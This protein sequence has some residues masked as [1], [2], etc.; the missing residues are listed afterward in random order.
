MTYSAGGLHG[1][2]FN[3]P[4]RALRGVRWDGS[5]QDWK[6]APGHYGA[7]H[8]SRRQMTDAGWLPG[9]EW[10]VPDGLASGVYA[11]K[12]ERAG[13]EDHVVFFVRPR[14]GGRKQKVAFL[15]ST[16]TYLAYANDQFS[17]YAALIEKRDFGAADAYLHDHPEVGLS[18]YDRHADGS[19]IA[20][21]F[22]SAAPVSI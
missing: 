16:A 7:V 17:M 22:V 9:I 4:T 6:R 14:P 2:F 3:T 5:E 11:M 18:L 10:N 19:G 13:D 12:L 8:F 15:A 1:T 21:L 20:L